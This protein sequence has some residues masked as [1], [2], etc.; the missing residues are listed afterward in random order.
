MDAPHIH[1]WLKPLSALYGAGVRLRNY[2]FDKNVLKSVSYPLPI[3]CVGNITVGGT[4]KTPHVEYLIRLLHTHYRLAVVSR[5]YKRKTKGMIIA[6]ADSSA[7]E[8]G[9]EPCQIK[10]KFP[11]LTVVVDAD[12]RR[13]IA[14]L[15]DLPSE[16][17]PQLILLDD[18]YQHR[19]VR[20][21]FSIVLTDYNRILTKDCLMPAGRLREP[22]RALHR[23]DTVILTKCPSNL[24]PIELRAAERDLALYPH[25]KLFFSQLCYQSELT[26]LFPDQPLH[27]TASST[28]VIAGIANSEPFFHEIRSRFPIVTERIYP[29]HHEFTEKDIRILIK[30]WSDLDR[31]EN[32]IIVCTEKDAMRLL[33]W[34]SSFPEKMLSR[35]FFL[36]VEAKLMFDQECGFV[37]KLLGTIQN[38]L[39][40]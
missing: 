18:G 19:R 37:N 40:S 28:L 16:Q 11:F 36:P 31:K 23:A 3:V 29:D 20:A 30:E 2:L 21:D 34:R 12:R 1:K 14:Y 6:S 35:L 7:Q 9:D 24:A 8:I 26:P 15:C 5:G 38:K 4:G 25:Q 32:T 27:P 13:A 22:I 10:Q 39:P 17:R 33:L